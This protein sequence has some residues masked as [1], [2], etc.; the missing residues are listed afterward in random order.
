MVSLENTIDYLI[1]CVY[2]NT[3]EGVNTGWMVLYFFI[4]FGGKNHLKDQIICRLCC[5]ILH[6]KNDLI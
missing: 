1:E 2:E 4:S 3:I 6:T 5:V